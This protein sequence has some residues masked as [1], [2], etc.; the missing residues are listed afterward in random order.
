MKMGK[1]TKYFQMKKYSAFFIIREI[2]IEN[3][4]NFN[5][6]SVRMVII[7]KT[8]KRKW[9]PGMCRK[10]NLDILLMGSKLLKAAMEVS[11]EVSSRS[12][13]RTVFLSPRLYPKE[14]KS[15]CYRHTYIPILLGQHLQ[16]PNCEEFPGFH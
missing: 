4:L 14:S 7:K 1:W 6:T 15:V 9:W 16:C 10:R 3:M 13:N 12:K 5:V 2:Q 11:T 8:S